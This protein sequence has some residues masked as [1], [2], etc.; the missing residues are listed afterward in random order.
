MEQKSGFIPISL[1]LV[2]INASKSIHR[3]SMDLRFWKAVT[4]YAYFT[5]Q[6]FYIVQFPSADLYQITKCFGVLGTAYV[7]ALAVL[8]CST[9]TM[10]GS[11]L[12]VVW[13]IILQCLIHSWPLK[14]SVE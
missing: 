1:S 12:P 11:S 4:P 8:G 13:L 6:Y 9:R 2:S 7:L 10:S 3:A 5:V 14:I